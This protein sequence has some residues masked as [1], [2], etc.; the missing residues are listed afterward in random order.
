INLLA[1]TTFHLAELT[2]PP[3]AR[4][5][6]IYAVGNALWGAGGFTLFWVYFN[7]RQFT[8]VNTPGTGFRVTKSAKLA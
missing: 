3:P 4:Y 1:I 8:L 5:P 6:D 7:Y 2:V